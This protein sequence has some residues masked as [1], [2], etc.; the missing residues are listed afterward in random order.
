MEKQFTNP[1]QFF[2]KRYFL[3]HSS[4]IIFT[5]FLKLTL[6]NVQEFADEMIAATVKTDQ[7]KAYTEL[8]EK[9][10]TRLDDLG[11]NTI[12]HSN[13]VF[14]RENHNPP[15]VTQELDNQVTRDGSDEDEL[16]LVK[17]FPA[18]FKVEFLTA[19]SNVQMLIKQAQ[20]FNPV[21]VC[22]SDE[23]K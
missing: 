22:I 13:K 20:M 23:S 1:K 5:N 18:K 11:E 9:L 4:Y 17:E 6:S 7:D 2:K 15:D 10:K 3:S 21:Y 14:I 12:F 16:N 8:K 19:N